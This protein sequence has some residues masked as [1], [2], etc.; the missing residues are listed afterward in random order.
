MKFVFG[1]VRGALCGALVLVLGVFLYRSYILYT[2]GASLT[3]V[4]L[5]EMLL[6]VMA[7]HHYAAIGAGVGAAV[8]ALFRLWSRWPDHRRHP[9]AQ[10]PPA[11]I[12]QGEADAKIKSFNQAKAERYLAERGRHK[13]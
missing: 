3:A 7:L 13:H 4:P 12:D 10:R 2:S 8:S 5:P 9:A 6:D 1:L 11:T